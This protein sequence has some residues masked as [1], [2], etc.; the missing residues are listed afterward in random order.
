LP[1]FIHAGWGVLVAVTIK[2]IAKR[3]GRS[4]TTVSRALHDYEDVSEETKALVRAVAA[5]MGYTPSSFAQR[6]QKQKTDTIGLILPTYGPRFTDP[7]FS[8][9]L[10]GVGNKAGDLG[11][12]IL[13]STC[14][15]GDQELFNYQQKTQ[16]R[17]VDGFII[18]RTRRQ[19]ARIE[20]LCKSKTPFVAFGRTQA[21]CKYAYVDEDSQYG[22]RLMVDHLVQQ[23]YRRLSYLSAPEELMFTEF[24][25]KGF[26]NGLK[27]NHLP[28]DEGLI[29]VGDLTHR[30]GYAQANRL[31]DLPE[32]PDAIVASNDLMAIGAMSAVQ[33]RG[34]R[35]GK[36]IAIT[37][38]DDTTM[39][40][41]T[42]PP[43]T[44]I[45]QP[46]YRIGG[47]VTD[48]LIRIIQGETLETEQ[49]LLQPS[50]VIRQSCGESQTIE[51]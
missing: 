19:D 17:R 34:L 11:Y 13:V 48:M 8:E 35:V 46:V 21:A 33:E 50:L 10:A 45:H 47:M 1:F 49:I 28:H 18:V 12:D 15:P 25:L 4:V 9:F 14:P 2:D 29:V 41:H 36:D 7:F 3:V 5:E 6:L 51:N 40:E 30:G 23:G 16:T 24:R 32:P 42:H 31:L 43:L 22:M 39:S 44:T 26:L 38:F 27:A 37:G 20:Y